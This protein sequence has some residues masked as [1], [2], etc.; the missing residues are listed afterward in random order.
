MQ[1]AGMKNTFTD[2]VR[3]WFCTNK[4]IQIYV[5]DVYIFQPLF[6]PKLNTI[7]ISVFYSLNVMT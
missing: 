3:N 1:A 2:G 7:N 6:Y 4:Y 5:F